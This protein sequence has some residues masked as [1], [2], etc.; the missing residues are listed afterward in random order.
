ME[1]SLVM[2]FPPFRLDVVNQRLW[3]GGQALDLR[4]KTFAVLH[5][6]LERGGRLVT[7]TELLGAVW[8]ETFVGDAV[9]K[10][11]IRELRALLGDDSQTPLYLATVHR[12]GYRFIA[13]VEVS[14][15]S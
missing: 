3:R 15:L 7:K 14:R 8:R 5:Y 2:S 1:P 6:L 13:R 11:C 4:P 12:R 10:N 9:L